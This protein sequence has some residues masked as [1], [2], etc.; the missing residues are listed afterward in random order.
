MTYSVGQKLIGTGTCD[1]GLNFEVVQVEPVVK[2]KC[3]SVNK[4]WAG[5]RLEPFPKPSPY[6]Q[7]MWTPGEVYELRK[8]GDGDLVAEDCQMPWHVFRAN[9][10]VVHYR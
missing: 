7:K 3:L 1:N 4:F 10:E 8:T 9:G 2:V 6:H 5:M